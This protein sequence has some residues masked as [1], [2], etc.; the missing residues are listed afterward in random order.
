M[1]L[2]W[3]LFHFPCRKKKS[4]PEKKCISF[5]FIIRWRSSRK[6]NKM[7][8]SWYLFKNLS[9]HERKM[10]LPDDSVMLHGCRAVRTTEKNFH[11]TKVKNFFCGWELKKI[12][13]FRHPTGWDGTITKAGKMFT[14]L[15]CLLVW[16]WRSGKQQQ[17]LSFFLCELMVGFE[18]FCGSFLFV[19]RKV[20][21]AFDF[22]NDFLGGKDLW[23]NQIYEVP[24][25]MYTG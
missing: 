7:C 18:S 2:C 4:F 20:F 12:F 21:L 11:D 15:C 19:C 17:N 24:L 3:N 23:F 6:C 9:S 14:F 5:A 25:K 1:N 16:W 8:T 22:I 13:I 10:K